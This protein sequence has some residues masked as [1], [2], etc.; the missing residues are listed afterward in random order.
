M[1]SQPKPLYWVASSKKDLKALPEEVQDIFG[2]ALHLAQ[3]GRKHDQT[4]PLKGFGSAG[5]LEVVEDYY[6]DTYRAVYTVK[7]ANAVYVLHCFQKKSSHGIA[8]PK[9]DLDLI[10]ERLKAAETHA[11]GS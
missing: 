5:V 2:F 3:A 10:R 4:K 1:E 11:K 8:T 6:G 9:P 7:L